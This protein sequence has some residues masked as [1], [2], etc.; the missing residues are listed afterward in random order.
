MICAAIRT[1]VPTR[2][3]ACAKPL[4][5]RQT[6]APLRASPDDAPGAAN[7]AAKEAAAKEAAEE[8]RLEAMESRLRATGGS[9]AAPRSR[10]AASQEKPAGQWAAW[11][12]GQL[13]PEGWE[14]MDPVEKATELYLGERGFLYWATQLTI[15]GLVVLVVAWVA[16]RFIG[17]SFGLYALEN[18]PNL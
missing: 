17:P 3:T 16:F 8:A 2:W 7:D 10:S 6:K 12:E 11:K 9:S 1:P 5:R 18:D 13:F 15:G 14:E 4:T